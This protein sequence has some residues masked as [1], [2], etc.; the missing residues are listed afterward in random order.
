[1]K[2][3]IYVVVLQTLPGCTVI[4]SGSSGEKL[5]CE[6]HESVAVILNEWAINNFNEAYEKTG[7]ANGAAVQL[8]L[9]EHKSPSPYAAAFNRYQE[10]AAEN[11]KLANK[12][13]AKFLVIQL[14]QLMS[15]RDGLKY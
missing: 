12:K 15:S 10:K 2:N 13:A 14:L 3:I 4:R 1:M 8:F 7:D 6:Q 11:I 9:I 5:T